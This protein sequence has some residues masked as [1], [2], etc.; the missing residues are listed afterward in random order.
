VQDPEN[1]KVE[2]RR[3]SMTNVAIV[4]LADTESNESLGRVVNALGVAKEFNEEGQ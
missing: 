1:I 3:G 4:I 2:E